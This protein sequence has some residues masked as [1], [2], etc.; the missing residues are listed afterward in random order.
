M[1]RLTLATVFKSAH[2]GS[3]MET[4]RAALDLA[5]KN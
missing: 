3:I 1:L 2:Q 4:V 5:G